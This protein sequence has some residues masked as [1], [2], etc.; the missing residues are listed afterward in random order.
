MN[1]PTTAPPASEPIQTSRVIERVPG[2]YSW[3]VLAAAT[4]GL[5][6][7]IPGQTVGFSV[8]LDKIIADLGLGRST[9]SAAYTIGTL[10]GSF[11]LPFVGRAIDRHGPRR[12]VIVIAVA[13]GLACG[14]LGT[15]TG[16]AT[17]LVGF[18][19]IRGLGQ[20][21][22]GLVS[23]HSINIWFVRRRG[24]AV[25]LAGVGFAIGTGLA[26][27]GIGHL[28]DSV[29]W[30]TAYAILGMIVVAVMVP[31]GGG[32]FRHRP[33]VY[34]LLPDTHT[35]PNIDTPAEVH[36]EAR[37]ARRTL[38]FWLYVAGG[39]LVAALATGLVFHHY[40]I[41][42]ESGIARADASA[43]FLLY[44][45]GAAGATFST[46][47]LVDRLPPRFLLSASLGLLTTALLVAPRVSTLT[48]VMAYGVA[49]GVSQGMNQAL[50]S[51]VYAHYFG[52]LHIG[53][54][55]GMASTVTAAGSAAG[56][57]LVA[58]GF[59]I[60]ASYV[61]VLALCA[62]APGILALTAPFLPLARNGRIL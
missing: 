8:F 34:G 44:G 35:P 21:A 1:T 32:L 6:M 2:H 37:Q 12:S 14:F 27:I 39:F 59:D 60:S 11:S 17:L 46:G 4:I 7:T 3:V 19:L 42:T 54:I 43:M 16:L 62:I 20:G 58:V 48:T 36:Y 51:S 15:A 10:V 41:M 25:G 22:M 49:L 61:P 18:V 33:E 29:G 9:V 45:L 24:L 30:R 5:I 23:I 38:T 55:K 56:P 57:L 31:V 52:R 40:S 28:V 47:F 53:A 26:P 50:Q 13:F